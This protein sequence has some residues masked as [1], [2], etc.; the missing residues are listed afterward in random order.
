MGN[1]LST[2]HDDQELRKYLKYTEYNPRNGLTMTDLRNLRK[3]FDLLD[4]DKKG[5]IIYDINKLPEC[6]K[7]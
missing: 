7:L 3:A 5:Y 2:Q 4:T 1:D 6:M